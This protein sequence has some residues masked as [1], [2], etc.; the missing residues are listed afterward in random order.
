MRLCII[1][2]ET[3]GL[4]TKKDN[5]IE[6]GAIIYEVGK[7]NNEMKICSY[8]VNEN[9]TP[10]PEEIVRITGI[11]DDTLEKWGVS[12]SQAWLGIE[13]E[14]SDVDCFVA[15]NAQFD[16]DML[17]NNLERRTLDAKILRSTPWLCTVTDIR[18]SDKVRCRTLSHMALDYGLTVDPTT[19]HRAIDDC[20]LLGD[21]LEARGISFLEDYDYFMKPKVTFI[22]QPK[23]PWEDQGTQK[24]MAVKLGFS[25]NPGIKR[26]EAKF[27]EDHQFPKVPFKIVKEFS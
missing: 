1:D 19:L 12:L 22:A 6:I 5:V 16:R 15:H 20:H 3:T 27:P 9:Y 10:L 11:D 13:P 23:P 14:L 7:W 21:V 24:N 8:L 17:I 4:D 2:T 26:W 18:H 25:W